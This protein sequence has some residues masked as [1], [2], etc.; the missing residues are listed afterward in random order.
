MTLFKNERAEDNTTN[1]QRID[2]G[3]NFI[4]MLVVAIAFVSL[5]RKVNEVESVT[6]STETSIEDLESKIERLDD[7]EYKIAELES[8]ED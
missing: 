1:S 5:S 2:K 4:V 8:L 7:V 3:A 6:T